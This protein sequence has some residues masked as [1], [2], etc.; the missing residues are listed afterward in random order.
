MPRSHFQQT[1]ADKRPGN[2]C[3]RHDDGKRGEHLCCLALGEAVANHRTAQ[4]R[5]DACAYCLKNAPKNDRT[6][7][8]RQCTTYRTNHEQH[9]ADKQRQLALDTVANRPPNQ[10]GD[11]KPGQE[12]RNGQ[13]CI[14]AQLLF[15]RRHGGQIN[16]GRKRGERHQRA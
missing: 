2:R 11:G 3:N 1:A 15:H 12:A 4:H 8:F 5:P 9:H 6:H 10:L 16:I 7:G 13:L 14:I